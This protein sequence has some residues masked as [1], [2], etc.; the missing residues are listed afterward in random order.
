[1][2]K[3]EKKNQNQI[4][5]V[6]LVV[7]LIIGLLLFLILRKPKYTVT[8]D[9]EGGNDIAAVKVLKNAKLELPEDPTKEGFIFQ[10][11][12]YEDKEFAKETK[13]TK[14]ITLK[15]KWAV[16][17]EKPQKTEKKPKKQVKHEYYC[18]KGYKLEGKKCTKIETKPATITKVDSITKYSCEDGYKIVGKNCTRTIIVNAKVR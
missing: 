10:G 4:I 14:D 18:A 8:F 1:M 13:I 12:I 11:W 16:K 5:I 2:K 15:A 9:T 17:E 7:L 3:K 6:T